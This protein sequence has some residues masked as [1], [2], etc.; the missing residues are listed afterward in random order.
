MIT[1]CLSSL[2]MT[3]FLAILDYVDDIIVASNDPKQVTKLKEFLND[4][5]K[6]KDLGDLKYFLGQEVARSNTGISISQRKYA[7]ELLEEAGLS[8]AKQ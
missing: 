8:G 4:K 1:H 3:F 5:F 6:L 7:F 2:L